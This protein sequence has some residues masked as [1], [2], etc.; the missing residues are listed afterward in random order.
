MMRSEAPVATHHAQA[1]RV[2][3]ATVTGAAVFAM[4][5]VAAFAAEWQ[6]ARQ[7]LIMQETR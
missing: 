7:D 1:Q 5:L 3:L 4:V 6:Q 2:A